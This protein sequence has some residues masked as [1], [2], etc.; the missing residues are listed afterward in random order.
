MHYCYVLKSEETGQLFTG[1]TQ[2]LANRVHEHNAGKAQA[3]QHG[4]PWLLV[5]REDFPSREQAADRKKHFKTEQG[6]KEL[7]ALLSK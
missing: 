6:G 1:Y 7:Q 2:H 3:T 4:A 5:Y